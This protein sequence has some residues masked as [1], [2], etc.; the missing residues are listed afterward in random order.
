ML[1]LGACH[2]THAPRDVLLF[3]NTSR[4][5]ETAGWSELQFV[6]FFCSQANAG[7]IASLLF[8]KLCCAN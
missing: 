3:V 5:I 6:E 7:S 4:V 1:A 2:N 8:E